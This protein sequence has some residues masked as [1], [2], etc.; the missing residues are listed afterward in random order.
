M[1]L[2]IGEGLKVVRLIKGLTISEL[3]AQTGLH[4]ATHCKVE[5]SKNN[6]TS[7][8]TIITICQALDLSPDSIMKLLFGDLESTRA[9][10]IEMACV[11]KEKEA[12]TE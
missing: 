6:R 8:A 5:T 2:S 11:E 10:I 12:K 3:S 1:N 9:V 7:Y 4:L